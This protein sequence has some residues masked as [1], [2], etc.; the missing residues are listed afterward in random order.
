[1]AAAHA[2]RF[3][4]ARGVSHIA[5]QVP[6]AFAESRGG[7]YFR[8]AALLASLKVRT[9]G[10]QWWSEF[11]SDLGCYGV[12]LGLACASRLRRCP[13]RVAAYITVRLLVHRV[14][15]PS[16]YAVTIARAPATRFAGF[17]RRLWR[18][19]HGATAGGRRQANA[20]VRGLLPLPLT[21]TEFVARALG[22]EGWSHA[23]RPPPNPAYSSLYP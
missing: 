23:P 19:H 10:A 1:M 13:M 12:D 11:L 9:S 8:G 5:I 2:G 21:Q 3:A 14:H 6:G 22:E 4:L 17:A 7:H 15:F 18:R 20:G 16:Q